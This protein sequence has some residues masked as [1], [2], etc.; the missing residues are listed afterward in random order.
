MEL[1]QVWA[2]RLA[3]EVAPEEVDLAPAMAFAF[4]Q[5][6]P[7]RQELFRR[8]EGGVPGAFTPGGL[9]VLM[10]WVLDALAAA[11][12]LLL[13]ILVSGNAERVLRAV[14]DLLAI[15]DSLGA[16]KR[17]ASASPNAYAPLRQVVEV[18][19]REL[20]AA[21]VPPEQAEVIVF[22]VLRVLLEDPAG[23]AAFVRQVGR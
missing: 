2:A 20:G 22:R 21:R 16:K 3:S 18:M 11:A 6:G 14:R 15:R 8:S 10:P 23:A 5:G 4:V 7:A 13:S 19:S 9:P 17:P 12:P 1:V